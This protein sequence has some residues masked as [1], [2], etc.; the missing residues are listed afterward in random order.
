MFGHAAGYP[1]LLRRA[2]SFAK[3]IIAVRGACRPQ[4]RLI[5]TFCHEQLGLGDM[6]A[7]LLGVILFLLLAGGP[8]LLQAQT[9]ASVNPPP[10]SGERENWMISFLTPAEQDQYAKARAKALADNPGLKTD[11]EN[12]LKRGEGVMAG[13]TV[14]DK[15]AFIEKMNSHRQKLRQAML[16]VD[17]TL[18]PIFVQIDKHISEMKAKHL[19]QVQNN[20]PP[21][22]P[23]TGH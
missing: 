20:A 4:N 12:L 18:E 1:K 17:P 6:R 11:G 23:S 10:A 22:N 7:S 13:G 8:C 9:N 21:A 5:C 3:K 14:A 15:Q 2:A 19:G 16:K